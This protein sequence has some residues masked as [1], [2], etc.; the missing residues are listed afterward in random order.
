MRDL[1]KLTYSSGKE[2]CFVDPE[3]VVGITPAPAHVASG[4][5]VL[6]MEWGHEIH[7]AETTEQCYAMLKQGNTPA[8]QDTRPARRPKLSRRSR[9]D[10]NGQQK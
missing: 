8:K 6:L 2:P 4:G 5:C 7:V 3:Q 1:V 9:T 10:G